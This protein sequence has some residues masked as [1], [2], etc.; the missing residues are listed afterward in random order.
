MTCLHY[1]LAS[2]YTK[3]AY[4]AT[5]FFPF[6][7]LYVVTL[8]Q[9]VFIDFSLHLSRQSFKRRDKVFLPFALFF[10]ATE[11]S[12]VVTFFW[13]CIL[14]FVVIF[15][16]MSRQNSGASSGALLILCRDRIV[17]CRDNLSIV[18]L[19]SAWSLL[20]HSFACCD[21]LLQVALG[22]CHDIVKLC[23]NIF[24]FPVLA[25]FVAF[26]TLFASFALKAI[27]T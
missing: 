19:H 12:N 7:I 2:I 5:E 1:L 24:H 13:P 10:V 27:K 21:K 17:K 6:A 14:S 15:L 16:Y 23:C 25:I 8:F 20:R 26:S 4:V 3:F 22:F 18:I 9:R 11:L